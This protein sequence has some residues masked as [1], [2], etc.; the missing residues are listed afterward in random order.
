[1]GPR[2][3][4]LK[5][6]FLIDHFDPQHGG[7]ESYA[8]GLA[9][10]LQQQ[11][12]HLTVYTLHAL[13]SQISAEQHKTFPIR[14]V[15]IPCK[16]RRKG[17]WPDECAEA[18][19]AALEG[20]TYDLIQGFNHVR[21]GDVLLLGGGLHVA[22][23]VFNA[24]S[25]SSFW[26]RFLKKISHRVLPPY[27]ALRQNEIQQ[28]SAPTRRFIAVSERVRG[29]M[30]RVYPHCQGRV[31][32]IRN[33]VDLEHYHPE[34][35]RQ[36]RNESRAQ[37]ALGEEEHVL[38]FVAHN[39]RLKGLHHL[40]SA[41]PLIQKSVGQPVK[42]LVVGRGRSRKYIQQAKRLGVFEDVVFAGS[43]SDSRAAYAAADVLVHPSFYDSFGL[44][45]LEAMACGRP[46]VVSRNC[47]VAEMVP[48]GAA[49]VLID[50]PCDVDTLAEA[51]VKTLDTHFQE[52]AP[53]LQR[54]IAEE[55]PI[56]E[57]Y[58]AVESLY[59]EI[60]ALKGSAQG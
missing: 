16:R 39:F 3:S 31:H 29:D 34:W 13:S 28:F 2:L 32:L 18:Y 8:V 12:H 25:E 1:M 41:L 14:I 15:S 53:A 35:V 9:R 60:C 57:N 49:T 56:A 23:E 51:V 6:A 11:G 24:V 19:A 37:W 55:L 43:V 21:Q 20:E 30:H 4:P 54:K 59:E 36:H 45:V 47:G 52:H 7:A 42:C 50:M 27:R 10:H 40:I 26:R 5:I 33:G 44:V 58:R 17:R 38:L 48:E 22:Y 46:V